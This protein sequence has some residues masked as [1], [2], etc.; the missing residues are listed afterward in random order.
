MKQKLPPSASFTLKLRKSSYSPAYHALI[1]QAVEIA[2]HTNDGLLHMEHLFL[3]LTVVRPNSFS[4]LLGRELPFPAISR[5][6]RSTRT[7]EVFFASDADRYLSLY[8]GVLGNLLKSF[9]HPVEIDAIHVAA[10]LLYEPAGIVRE[11]LNFSGVDSDP[12]C[13]RKQI[14]AVLTARDNRIRKCAARAH[15][16]AIK[17]KLRN[18]RRRLAAVCFGQDAAIRT[19]ITQLDL[20]WNQTAAE[21]RN[22]PLSFCL[23]GASGTGKSLL[24]ET[25]VQ[26]LAEE[27]N[28]EPTPVLDMSRYAAE[29]VALDLIGR[30]SSWKDGGHAGEL[31]RCAAASPNGLIL[32]ENFDKAHPAAI[33]YLDTMLTDGVLKDGHTGE[34]VSFAGNIVILTSSRGAEFL[35]SEKFIKMCTRNSGA[36]PRDKLIDGFCT[37]VEQNFYLE[38]RIMRQI[39]NK[40]DSPV[41]FRKYQVLTLA[42]IVRRA[43]ETVLA[44]LKTVSRLRPECNLDDLVLFFLETMQNLDSAHGI[45]QMVEAAL[46]VP[47]QERS[48]DLGL[49]VGAGKRLRI[50]LDPLPDIGTPFSTAEPGTPEWL[51]AREE[52]RIL[53]AKRLEYHPEVSF[54][55]RSITL[56]LTGLHYEVMPSIEDAG[57]FSVQPPDVTFQ[58]LVGMEL[59]IKK[60]QRI[61]NHFRYP[62]REFLKPE[63]GILLHG[64]AGTGKTSFA[65]A[66]AH[67]LG[68]PFIAVSAADFCAGDCAEG[69]LRV[70][71]LF[72][73]AR[74]YQAIVFIDEID[75][76]GSRTNLTG[77]YAGTI[78][79]LLTELDG[80]E[81][82][83]ILV[84]AATNRIDAIDP[85]LLRP[86]RLHAQIEIGLLLDP[87]DRA[88]LIRMICR[89]ANETLSEEL[90]QFIVKTTHAWS[91]A[92]LKATVREAFHLA[93]EKN[94]QMTRADYIAARETEFYGERTQHR[95]LSAKL[96]RQIAVH[97]AGHAVAAMLHGFHWIQLSLGGGGGN[98][99][100]FLE[101]QLPETVNLTEAELKANIDIALAG[102]VA[103][104]LLSQPT[105]GSC[106]DFQQATRLAQRILCAGFGERAEYALV[107]MEEKSAGWTEFLPGINQ[108]IKERMTA[109][110]ELLNRNIELLKR[111]ADELGRRG[112]LFED[113]I[114]T[115]LPPEVQ[116]DTKNIGTANEGRAS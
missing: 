54:E 11:F 93:R 68:V 110:R 22:R 40:V 47:I 53:L 2:R 48:L 105:E 82:R 67:E 39:L 44:R 30:D 96:R 7:R 41:L 85:A 34:N 112:I 77:P 51:Q 70:R 103:E 4:E 12:V 56:H 86:G 75:A 100:G 17:A 79:T 5:P 16:S 18:I 24:A 35:E 33:A 102:R 113:E 29:Q 9:D 99:L 64:P 88:R 65:K 97:E 106:H 55:R 111:I 66:V 101:Y 38:G 36:I 84:I 1:R 28:L 90:L 10:A 8:G 42:R 50:T 61:L 3:A 6:G 57:Y 92:S 14:R 31:T 25:L 59:P 45:E 58:E 26:A 76:V 116:P 32:I 108:I 15:A 23:I 13:L 72:R 43:V 87:A 73:V 109:T 78:N 60:V 69:V 19:V 94:R 104:E 74:K 107:S 20:F 83:R 71:N 98:L 95:K 27:L 114:S 115:F 37:I 81:E 46:Y 91:P 62:E 89:Q 21:R 80:F 63:T 49:T 52:K